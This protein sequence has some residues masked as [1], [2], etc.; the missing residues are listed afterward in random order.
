MKVL[1]SVCLF[2]LVT[3]LLAQVEN[4]KD[5]INRA[6]ATVGLDETL[7]GLIT[8]QI[9]GKLEPAG[10]KVPPATLLIIARK[11]CSQR[12]EIRVDDIVET[13]ILNNDEGCLIRSNLEAGASQM[14]KLN[15]YL[16]T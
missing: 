14:R 8:L 12:M 11:P 9:T 6:R 5:V 3:P 16:P 4:A 10:S 15:N 1:L 7:D 13:H 2:A